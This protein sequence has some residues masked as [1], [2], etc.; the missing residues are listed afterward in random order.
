M[1]EGSLMHG[2]C[3]YARS[4]NCRLFVPPFSPKM[5]DTSESRVRSENRK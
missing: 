4:S 1:V 2:H 3:E 5:V